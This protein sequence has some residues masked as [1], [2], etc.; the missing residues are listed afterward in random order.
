M[1]KTFRIFQYN[2][3]SAINNKFTSMIV[4]FNNDCYFANQNLWF[5]VEIYF[6]KILFR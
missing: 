1:V 4:V 5:Y 6:I 3:V 2:F